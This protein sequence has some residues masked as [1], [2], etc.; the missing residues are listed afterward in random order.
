MGY[1]MCK[2]L[3]YLKQLIVKA[4]FLTSLQI[5]LDARRE[6]FKTGGGPANK[7]C[8]V[9]DELLTGILENQQPLENIPDDDHLD[10]SDDGSHAP[11][12]REGQ[13]RTEELE[14]SLPSTSSEAR[15][16][17]SASTGNQKK[18]LTVYEKLANDFHEHKLKYLK[19]EH[20]MKIKMKEREMQ[21]AQMSH[22][23]MNL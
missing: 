3:R 11:I 8:D 1:S 17:M 10:S 20:E 23:Y 6:R 5:F 21:Q 13:N 15:V 7:D 14:S 18:R 2:K 9:L 16:A 4:A 12:L 19:E 22:Q